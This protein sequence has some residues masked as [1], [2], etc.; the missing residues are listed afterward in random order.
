MKNTLLASLITTAV[1]TTPTVQASDL[2]SELSI[3]KVRI[4]QLESQ[5]SDTMTEQI[6]INNNRSPVTLSGSAEFL[7]TASEQADGSNE[8][9]L[10]VDSVELTIDA[11]VN[12]YM[13]LSTTLK[14]EDEGEDQDLFVDEAIVTISSEE[15]PW[16]LV[17]GRTAIP[18]AVINGNAWSDPLT[19]DLTDNTDDLLFLGFSQGMFSA[20]GYL[21][22]GQSDE[23]K[24]DNL[25]L[26]AEL[27]FDNGFAIGVGYLNNIRNTEP[28]QADSLTGD[29]KVSASRIN[30]S[31]AINDLSLSAEYLKTAGFDELAGSPELSA[32]HVSTDYATELMGAPGNLSLGYSKTA[33]GEQLTDTGDNLFAHSRVTLGAS[34]ELYE[35]AE[36]IVELV[37]EED[38][39]GDSSDALNL[40]LSTRF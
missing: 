22:K 32:W 1:A 17:A 38:Y 18:F 26:N 10:D 2:Q 21:F 37:R 20:G 7:A 24:V 33:D 4:A 9:D 31:Y 36:L 35:N 11:T 8:N 19:D 29:D 5:L 23:S 15:S 3:L 34:R 16:A 28:F 6:S 30:L 25:G 12:Q 14:Y 39:A 13:A 27:T 40:V